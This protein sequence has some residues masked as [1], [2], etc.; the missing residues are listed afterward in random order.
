MPIMK[1]FILIIFL[2]LAV[3]TKAQDTLE[4]CEDPSITTT[5]FS[6]PIGDG[7]NT[8]FVNGTQY[9]SEELTYTFTIPGVYTIILHRENG[10]CYVEDTIQVTI[11][12]C[13][14]IIYW[15]PNSFTPDSDEHNQLF[16][17][18]MTQGF[19]VNDFTFLIFNRWGEIVWESHDPNFMWDGTYHNRMCQDGV[20]TWKLQ[21]SV[22]GNDGRITDQGHLTLIR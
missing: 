16:G 20:Y 7:T 3:F 9:I 22:L 17:P 13:E 6:T 19:D 21:F 8:W 14:G 1:Q 10:P 15:V 18:V 5:F 11:S 12:K 2:I 4:I